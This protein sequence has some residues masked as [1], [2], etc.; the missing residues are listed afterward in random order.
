[1]VLVESA[2][3]GLIGGLL[4]CVCGV[5]LALLLT[6]VINKQFF[7]WSVR[8]TIDPWLFVQAVGLMLLTAMAAGLGPARMAAGRVAAEAMRVE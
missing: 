5:L 8:L 3:I 4:G 6:Y 2:L 1:M 7:G